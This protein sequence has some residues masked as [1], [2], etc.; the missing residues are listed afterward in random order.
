MYST[1]EGAILSSF[2]FIHAAD[3]HLGSPFQGLSVKDADIA[4]RFADA[5]RQAFAG[6]VQ[7]A[8]D[9]AVD[10]VII[11]GDIYDGD[12]K[13]STTGLFFNREIARLDRAG[14]PTYILKGNHDADSVI[15]RTISLPA[16]VNEFPTRKPATF[17]IDALKVALHG[18][19]F[20]E[21]SARENLAQS[22]PP[23]EPGWFNI[24]VLHTSL[25]GR[26]PHANY[27]PCSLEDLA[28]RGYDYWALGHVHEFDIVARDPYVVFPGNLQGRSIRETGAKGGVIV[29]V[30]EGR[31]T[32][33]ERLIV[34]E[35]RWCAA[36]VDISGCENKDAFLAHVQDA[37]RVPV[38]EADGRL[39]ALRLCLTGENALEPWLLAHRSDVTDEL[40]AI[41]HRLSADVWLEK[42]ELRVA[43]PVL[44]TGVNAADPSFDLGA[45]LDAVKDDPDFRQQAEAVIAE[46]TSKLPGGLGARPTPLGDDA[47]ALISE[48]RDILVYRASNG[49]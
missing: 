21:R 31:I 35:A 24:G 32:E 22:Y 25:T 9:D 36:L 30:E 26:P 8:V 41:C 49:A 33:V 13:D 42:L 1:H 17:K 10:F 45:L 38:A 18:Q 14:I 4:A 12:W 2:R 43:P 48:A 29:T 44:P 28:A 19:G 39:L 16:S 37:L 34:D 3:L 46:V 23:P 20:A 40:Q 47:A 27:A 15:S 6:L 5:T 11:A 7:K